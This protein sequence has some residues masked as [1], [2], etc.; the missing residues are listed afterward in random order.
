LTVPEQAQISLSMGL[1]LVLEQ[2]MQMRHFAQL[3]G[4]TSLFSTIYR[5]LTVLS[6]D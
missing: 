3:S 5:L 6:K 1:S 4:A 2:P